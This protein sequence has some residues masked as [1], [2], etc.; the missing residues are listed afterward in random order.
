MASRSSAL[1]PW[2]CK[3]SSAAAAEGLPLQLQCTALFTHTE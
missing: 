2:T 3:N 1:G